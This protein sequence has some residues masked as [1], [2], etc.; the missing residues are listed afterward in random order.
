M[1]LSHYTLAR[2][3]KVI[4]VANL[5]QIDLENQVLERKSHTKPKKEIR[6]LNAAT[7]YYEAGGVDGVTRAF[8]IDEGEV[9]HLDCQ[10]IKHLTTHHD[11]PP[12][13]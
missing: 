11:C 7:E 4:E 5:M 10:G 8:Q 3:G 13:N 6:F 12:R 2:L 1:E 9:R